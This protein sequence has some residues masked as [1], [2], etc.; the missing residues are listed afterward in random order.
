[1]G[2]RVATKLTGQSLGNVQR[3]GQLI[4]WNRE[5]QTD[6]AFVTFVA[7]YDHIDEEARV[8]DA[9]EDGGGH[10][11]LIGDA[12]NR[13]QRLTL[14]EQQIADEQ[15]FHVDAVQALH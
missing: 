7:L 11:R 2:D 14:I 9:L 10:S 15:L 13:D 8:G 6:P 1:M 3:L 4:G 12:D 5:A